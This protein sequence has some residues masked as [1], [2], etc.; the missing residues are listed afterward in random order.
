MEKKKKGVLFITFGVIIL[1]LGINFTLGSHLLKQSQTKSTLPSQ[2]TVTKK[3][4]ITITHDS[5]SYQGVEGKTALA[6]LK[7]KAKNVE[8]SN[9]GLVV[10]I[11]GRKAED[12]KKEFWAFYVN[13]EM[14]QVGPAEYITE[15]K[16]LIEWKIEHY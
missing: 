10:S 7:K 1:V 13:G 12:S 4:Q 9:S 15:D 6:L 8:L 5:F 16:D 11:N 3:E 2:Q 14:A